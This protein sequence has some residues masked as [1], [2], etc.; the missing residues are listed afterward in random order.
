MRQSKGFIILSNYCTVSTKICSS[1]EEYG[2]TFIFYSAR[3]SEWP[4]L[5][6]EKIPPDLSFRRSS[7][8]TPT[9]SNYVSAF[10]HIQIG[11]MQINSFFK[12]NADR[13]LMTFQ[14]EVTL[15]K[16]SVQPTNLLDTG[17]ICSCA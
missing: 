10:T 6:T 7:L 11:L 14:H 12:N 17:Q 9:C 4:L 1:Y 13:F 2:I 15:H 3:F 5:R 8:S 16:L